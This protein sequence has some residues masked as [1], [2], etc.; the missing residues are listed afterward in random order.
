MKKA[1]LILAVIALSMT[2]FSCGGGNKTPEQKETVKPKTSENTEPVKKMFAK[3]KYL[4]LMGL[5]TVD[6]KFSQEDW[7]RISKVVKAYDEFKQKTKNTVATTDELTSFFKD[8]GY[9]DYQEG[10]DDILKFSSLY[11]IAVGIPTNIGSLGQIKKMYGEEQFEKSC[12][13]SGEIYNDAHLS[14]E[15]I[16]NIEKHTDVIAKAGSVKIAI[17]AAEATKNK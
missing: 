7:D 17:E 5:T 9:A 16:K 15:D 6:N 2:L 4:D 12:K 14:A 1:T 13:E 11:Q 10:K 3:D 8:Q